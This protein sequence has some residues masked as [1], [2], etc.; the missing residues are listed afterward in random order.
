[1]LII[2][3]QFYTHLSLHFQFNIFH[4]TFT[5]MINTLIFDKDLSNHFTYTF[6]KICEMIKLLDYY[7][8]KEVIFFVGFSKEKTFSFSVRNG[9]IIDQI[10]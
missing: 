9:L 8:M 4:F 2:F 5:M 10:L 3:F 7:E 6:F 1:M